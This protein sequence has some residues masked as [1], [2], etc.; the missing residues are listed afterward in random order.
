MEKLC[1]AHSGIVAKINQL[2]KSDDSQWKE[3]NTLKNRFLILITGIALTFLAVI[4][5]LA[6]AL[7][8]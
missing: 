3:I 5:D 1:D 7:I 6:V 4:A 8:G 2:C